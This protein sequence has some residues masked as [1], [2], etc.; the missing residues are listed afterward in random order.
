M[1][2]T[3]ETPDMSTVADLTGSPMPTAK[4]LRQRRS[5]PIQ[6]TRFIKMSLRIMRMAFKGH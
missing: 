6:F 2:S 1:E 4:T 3:N 5:V